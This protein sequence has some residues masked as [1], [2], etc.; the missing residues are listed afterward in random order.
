MSRF[1]VSLKMEKKKKSNKRKIKPKEIP[2]NKKCPF[3]KTYRNFLKINYELKN[4]NNT[5]KETIK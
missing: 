1:K 3:Y 4:G 2:S 5:T